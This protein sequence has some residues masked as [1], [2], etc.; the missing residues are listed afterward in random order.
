MGN[1]ARKTVWW[2]V[3]GGH[4]PWIQALGLQVIDVCVALNTGHHRED[5]P[6]G[7]AGTVQSHGRPVVFFFQFK[8]SKNLRKEQAFQKFAISTIKLHS[9]KP[10]LNLLWQCAELNAFS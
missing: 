9:D 6:D 7:W 5:C 2:N 1:V 10:V 3:Q 8:A 4:R